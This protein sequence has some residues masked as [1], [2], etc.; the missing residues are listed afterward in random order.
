M[1]VLDDTTFLAELIRQLNAQ[2]DGDATG[3]TV[4][5]ALGDA[6]TDTAPIVQRLKA[7]GL[8]DW[9]T[10]QGRYGDGWTDRGL[11]VTPAGYDRMG[12]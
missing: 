9:S 11:I 10:S 5:A 2:P 12:R 6:E 8:I 4:A 1:T 3:E 7:R